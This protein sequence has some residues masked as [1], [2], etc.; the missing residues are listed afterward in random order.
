M[1]D[2][3]RLLKSDIHLLLC[4]HVLLEESSVSKAATR[5]HL[6]QSAVS[7]QLTRLRQLFDDPLFERT[8]KGL[9]PTPKALSLA[10]RLRNA[11]QQIEMLTLPD[12]FD[13][14]SSQRIFNIDLVDT[15]YSVLYPKFMPTALSEAPL[16]TINSESWSELSFQ[17]LLKREIDFGLGVFEWDERS[18]L[19]VDT[20]P[21]ELSYIELRSDQSV[22]LLRRGHPALDEEWGLDTFLKYRQ[23]HVTTGGVKE[24]VVQE[25]LASQG[26][27]IDNAVNVSSITSAIQLCKQTDLIMYYPYEPIREYTLDGS[28]IVKPVPVEHKP[29]ALFLLWHKQFESDS[30]HRWLREL[31]IDQCIGE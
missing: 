2:V 11:L 17:R 13:A 30:G 20:I 21:E 31:I 25:V 28:L 19:Y 15:A 8:S 26:L 3:N 6:T 4:L 12:T 23:I 29:G 5:L 9:N 27:R 1:I 22:C 16:I 10:P 24:W 7:K 14:Q 18:K